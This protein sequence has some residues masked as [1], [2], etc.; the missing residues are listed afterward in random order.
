MVKGMSIRFKGLHLL[1]YVISSVE[2]CDATADAQSAN[3]LFNNYLK[4]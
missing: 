4:Q 2:G 3:S 1:A